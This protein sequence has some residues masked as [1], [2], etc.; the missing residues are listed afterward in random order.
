METC[1]FQKSIHVRHSMEAVSI[2]ASL[3]GLELADALAELDINYRLMGQ[4]AGSCHKVRRS[5][6]L[7]IVVVE[8]CYWLR[9]KPKISKCTM[10][11][12]VTVYQNL[13]M[14]SAWKLPSGHF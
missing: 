10:S 5:P 4:H 12:C 14:M 1:L 7:R 3:L 8:P 9:S 11:K 13:L 6:Q 2:S